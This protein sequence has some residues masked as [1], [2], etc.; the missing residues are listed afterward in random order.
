MRK[1]IKILLIAAGLFIAATPVISIADD[2]IM[3]EEIVGIEEDSDVPE[4]ESALGLSDKNSDEIYD[5]LD[6]LIEVISETQVCE[7]LTMEDIILPSPQ[8]QVPAEALSPILNVTTIAPSPGPEW[9]A[10]KYAEEY[11]NAELKYCSDTLFYTCAKKETENG[12]IY[13]LTH[14]VIKNANQINGSDSYGDFGGDRETPLDAAKRCGAKIL[15]NGSYFDYGTGHACGGSLL[16]RNNKVVHGESGSAR[17]ILKGRWF[18]APPV[19]SPTPDPTDSAVNMAYSASS[20]L[21]MN[22]LNSVSNCSRF[23]RYN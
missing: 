21:H 19:R 15:T 11:E 1:T 6:G 18:L 7:G 2:E 23:G 5:N 4:E 9:A 3:D 13:F 10:E 20:S 12:G 16:I 14:I 8:I 17:N 22:L